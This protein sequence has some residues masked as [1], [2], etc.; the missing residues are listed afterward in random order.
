MG[1][2]LNMWEI[3]ALWAL[4]LLG[5]LMTI[6]F[7]AARNPRALDELALIVAVC[8]VVWLLASGTI[9]INLK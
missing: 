7:I 2:G 4:G 6:V 3:A 9:S 8:F 1:R 5:A